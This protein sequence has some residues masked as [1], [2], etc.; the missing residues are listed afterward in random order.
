MVLNV[1]VILLRTDTIAAYVASKFMNPS[2]LSSL[3]SSV[4]QFSVFIPLQC[5]LFFLGLTLECQLEIIQSL[6]QFS[7]I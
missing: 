3:V 6:E 4:E 7:Y 2:E 1:C 5:L